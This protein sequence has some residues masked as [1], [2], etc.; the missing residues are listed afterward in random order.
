MFLGIRQHACLPQYARPSWPSFGLI[1]ALHFP[2]V[3]AWL[4]MD[5]YR[6]P[7][8]PMPSID[9]CLAE[10]DSRGKGERKE[11]RRS[12]IRTARLLSDSTAR[13]RAWSRSSLSRT[14]ARPF[15]R[16][17]L[18]LGRT[19]PRAARS[20]G[21]LGLSSG[22][23]AWPDPIADAGPMLLPPRVSRPARVMQPGRRRRR[24]WGINN[25]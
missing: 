21:G 18:R 7:C 4:R 17:S 11:Y 19:G 2:S 13:Q 10:T 15:Q 9:C 16:L 1:R 14:R 5:S 24:D 23:H 20:G 25:S 6:I 12:S 3:T 22:R 8:N